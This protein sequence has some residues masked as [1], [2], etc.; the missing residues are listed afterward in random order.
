MDIKY[1]DNDIQKGIEYDYS[2]I[3]KALKK[4]KVYVPDAYNPT[5][6]PLEKATWFIGL[7]ERGI[8]KTTGWILFGMEMYMQYGT[9]I[10]YIRES[11]NQIMPKNSKDL[12]TVIL[13]HD[14]I[15]KITNGQYNNVIYKSRRW[16]FCNTDDDGNVIDKSTDHFMMS[17]CIEKAMD[18]KSVYNAP[19]GDLIIFDE[20]IS[21]V[22][23][24][25]MFVSFLDLCK[26]II[27]DRHSAKIVL[28]ANTIDRHSQWF[29]ELLIHKEVVKMNT[30]QGD[31]KLITTSKGTKI[32]V[33]IIVNVQRREKKSISN[34]LYFGFD[35]P[36]I[37]SITGGDWA[38]DNYQHCESG[39]QNEIE[40]LSRDYYI[41]H[42]DEL[43]QIDICTH[44]K[45]E[46]FANLHF[47]NKTQDTSKIFTLADTFDD[48]YIY[49]YGTNKMHRFIWEYLYKNN[50][51]YYATNDIGEIVNDYVKQAKFL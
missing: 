45:R 40:Y 51:F 42:N 8:G 37:A 23:R 15:T 12:F 11:E 9:V 38:V 27:R 14:Y 32:Q 17:L 20:F 7:S 41:E 36:A 16:Y 13:E 50:L 44:P 29:H 31:T 21:R 35:N 18:L 33:S 24:P 49:K 5:H 47:A 30:L 10:Q 1:I 4:K 34:M 43:I 26:T 39:I 25:N 3:R 19:R 48:K 6:E 46:V 2:K 22:Y 28:V